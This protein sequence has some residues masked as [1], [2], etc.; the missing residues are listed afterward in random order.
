MRVYLVQHGEAMPKSED[1]A[2]PLTA[3]GRND[4][5]RV[6]AFAR[7]AG[8]DIFQ[9]RHSGKRRAEETAVILAE[10]L[11]PVH[12]VM[13]QA[14]LGPRDDVGPVAELLKRE[15][16][17]L[18][19]TGHLPFMDRLAGLLVAG[20]S[21]RSIVRFQQGGIVCLDRDPESW[22]WAVRWVVTPGLI[23]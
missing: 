6:A 20:D 12:G 14:G 13:V 8:V 1:P 22:T 7:R 15:T 11:E 19:L 4:V 9:I 2:R 17:P 10:H 23:S 18:M 21:Q 3:Q 16:Q 5:A